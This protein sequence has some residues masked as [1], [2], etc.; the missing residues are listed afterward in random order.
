MSVPTPVFW[1]RTCVNLVNSEDTPMMWDP[2]TP[3]INVDIPEIWTTSPSFNA[4]VVS[5]WSLITSGVSLTKT[6]SS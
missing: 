5:V 2:T 4:W 1:V 3:L 6:A